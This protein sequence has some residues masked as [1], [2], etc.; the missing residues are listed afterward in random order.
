MERNLNGALETVFYGKWVR[1]ILQTTL[2]RRLMQ[3]P[4]AARDS[5]QTQLR[6]VLPDA[7][8]T[9]MLVPP[10]AAVMLS[11]MQLYLTLAVLDVG[12]MLVSCMVL[13]YNKLPRSCPLDI[14]ALVV[15][16]QFA[17]A[18]LCELCF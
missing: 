16:G 15:R 6:H 4:R 3:T 2:H 7:I 5:C 12:V 13:Y 11:A 8:A 17:F 9:F 14:L 18:I 10:P 1:S